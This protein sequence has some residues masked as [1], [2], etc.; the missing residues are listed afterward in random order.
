[1]C[2]SNVFALDDVSQFGDWPFAQLPPAALQAAVVSPVWSKKRQ[3][4]SSW[5]CCPVHRV[6]DGAF[7]IGQVW[8]ERMR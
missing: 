2:I 7:Q 8:G 5:V 4:V 6:R 3:E 1:M